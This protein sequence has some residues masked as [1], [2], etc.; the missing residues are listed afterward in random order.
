MDFEIV[1]VD[2]CST[3][4]SF[5]KLQ[6]LAET[7]SRIKLFQNETNKGVGFTKRECV[8]KASG[9]I[10]AFVDPDDAVYET[11]L[12]ESFHAIQKNNAVAAYSQIMLCDEQLKPLHIY[13]RTQKIKNGNHFFFNI[14]N[15]VSH[16]FSFKKESYSKTA[17]INSELTSSVDFDLYLKLYEVGNFE[18]IEKPLYLYRQHQG[19]ISQNKKKKESV[20]R[21][22]NKVLFDTCKRRGI[23]KIGS[24]KITEDIDLSKLIFER[25]NNWVNK[26]K[27]KLF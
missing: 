24:T 3:D 26:L 12:E 5:Q 22:W 7:D 27:R 4:G 10:C 18:L 20:K 8:G 17:G 23:E 19:G 9:Q 14:N 2:D 13:P 25:E 16:F 11:A 6:Q 15:E 21:N 1:I